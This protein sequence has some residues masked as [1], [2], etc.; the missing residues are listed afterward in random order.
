MA[1]ERGNGQ[2][3]PCTADNL[4]AILATASI[5]RTSGRGTESGETA[6]VRGL[7]DGAMAGLL[8]Q[9]G[10]RRSEVAALRWSDL[11]DATDGQGLLITVRVSKTNQDGAAADVRYIKNG[12]AAALRHLRAHR[13]SDQDVAGDELVFGL[14]AQS[15]GHRF[16]AAAAA[17]GIETTSNRSLGPRRSSI[18]ADIRVKLCVDS[19]DWPR[20]PIPVWAHKEMFSCRYLNCMVG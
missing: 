2:A 15:I 16:T 10:L 19:D 9:G 4:A 12:A 3:P 18:R 14:T 13:F 11:T 1:S 6:R 8:F 7:E 20:R 5:P 17:A